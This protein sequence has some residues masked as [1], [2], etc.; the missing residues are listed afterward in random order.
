MRTLN[1]DLVIVAKI[2]TLTL[3]ADWQQR[4]IRDGREK[5][6]EESQK[7]AIKL[8]QVASYHCRLHNLWYKRL[9]EHLTVP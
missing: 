6:K 7:K 8:I 1:C 3:I 9:Y 4:L 2:K 5:E